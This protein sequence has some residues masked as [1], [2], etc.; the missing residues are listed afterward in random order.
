MATHSR[1]PYSTVNTTSEKI[2]ISVQ[3]QRIAGADRRHQL[4]RDRDQVDQDE[5]DQQPVDDD[6]Q[7]VAH[8][9]LLEDQ[10]DA[11]PQFLDLV[12]WHARAPL[13][14]QAILVHY[15]PGPLCGRSIA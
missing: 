15:G 5:R 14:S 4:E 6:A 10:I 9:A 11:P 7:A 2:S 8:R 1:K 12:A 13:E 3:S